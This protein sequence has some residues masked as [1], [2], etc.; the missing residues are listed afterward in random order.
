MKQ[1]N[2]QKFCQNHWT[3]LCTKLCWELHRPAVLNLPETG[4]TLCL[5]QLLG[6]V[7]TLWSELYFELNTFS[8]KLYWEPFQTFLGPVQ[9]ISS[10][11]G[12]EQTLCCEECLE[13]HWSSA[14]NCTRS[15]YDQI[16]A[17]LRAVKTL[18]TLNCTGSCTD[19]LLWT[20]LG[21]AE[22]FYS[23]HWTV[24]EVI[25]I[26]YS[27][28]SWEL[29]RSSAPNCTGICATS[30]NCPGNCKDPLL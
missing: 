24:L 16:W 23:V 27:K 15:W 10:E 5:K 28:L 6:T 2:F 12:T 29:Q 20:V 4:Q 7:Q 19:S 21:V 26:L 22:T 8:T 18:S 11:L 3:L 9:I 30:L 25:H 1:S 17:E 13:Q 14:L